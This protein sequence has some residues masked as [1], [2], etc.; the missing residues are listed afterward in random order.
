MP[1]DMLGLTEVDLSNAPKRWSAERCRTSL[2]KVMAALMVSQHAVV[3][4]HRHDNHNFFSMQAE[5]E[6]QDLSPHYQESYEAHKHCKNFF[7]IISL[8]PHVLIHLLDM[9]RCMTGA[10]YCMDAM[11]RYTESLHCVVSADVLASCTPLAV[12]C[13]SDLITASSFVVSWQMQCVSSCECM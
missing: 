8:C 7:G 10:V 2:T 13:V 12:A 1:Y 5:P 9:Q 3:T 6:P 4:P 11:V